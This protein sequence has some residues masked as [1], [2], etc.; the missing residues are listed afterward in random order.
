MISR[1]REISR[2]DQYRDKLSALGKLSAGLAHELNNPASAAH[3]AAEGLRDSMRELRGVNRTLADEVLS[4]DE[5]DL[6]AVF[7]DNLLNRA[8]SVAALDSLEQSD[9]EQELEPWLSEHGIL[10]TMNAVARTCQSSAMLPPILI[11]HL[12]CPPA[13]CVHHLL[14]IRR[15]RC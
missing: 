2:G 11:S 1:I 15:N 6:I 4:H 12:D 8:A 9:L 14:M 3:R 7:E 10:N 5:R 13:K